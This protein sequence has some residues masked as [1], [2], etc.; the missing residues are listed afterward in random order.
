[1]NVGRLMGANADFGVAFRTLASV[2]DVE[3]SLD[4]A[5]EAVTR[6]VLASNIKVVLV[7]IRIKA[8]IM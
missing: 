6:A 5:D 3:K 1:M 7:A 4:D 8:A 2:W